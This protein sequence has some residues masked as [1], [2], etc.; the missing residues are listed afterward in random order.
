MIDD[1]LY[2]GDELRVIPPHPT[3]PTNLAMLGPSSAGKKVE[4]PDHPMS[5]PSYDEMT[6]HEMFNGPSSMETQPDLAPV[7]VLEEGVAVTQD[8]LMVE[9][10]PMEESV[11]QTVVEYLQDKDKPLHTNIV[12]PNQGMYSTCPVFLGSF[13]SKQIVPETLCNELHTKVL[14]QWGT[15]SCDCGLVP[16]L[17]LSQTPRNK[18]SLPRLS[19]TSRSEIQLFSVDAS[20]P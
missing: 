3:V 20:G 14:N 11:A 12:L 6:L 9:W 1:P 17:Q 10:W 19:Q 4:F 18:N 7:Q 5:L 2:A 15:L 13:Q 8:G 16:T